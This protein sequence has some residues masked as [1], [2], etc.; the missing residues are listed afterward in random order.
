MKKKSEIVY[1]QNK[2]R[3]SP[4][5]KS[6]AARDNTVVNRRIWVV[7]EI[8]S[9]SEILKNRIT[10]EMELHEFV[11]ECGPDEDES[12]EIVTNWDE[13]ESFKEKSVWRRHRIVR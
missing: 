11:E 12:V 2:N 10:K 13:P 4:A 5:V 8:H 1:S 6:P 7:D 9:T 3:F